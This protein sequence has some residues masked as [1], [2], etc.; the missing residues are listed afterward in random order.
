MGNIIHDSLIFFPFD[1]DF[2]SDTKIKSLKAHYGADGVTFYVY[3]LCA[4][5]RDKGYYTVADVYFL[6]NAADDL[7]MSPTKIGL[8]LNFLLER[9][10]FNDKLFQSDKVLTSRGI[11]RRFQ[12]AIETR[13]RKTPRTVR[14]EIWL[15]EKDETESFIKCARF[16]NCSEKKADFSEK[17]TVILPEICDKGKE[18]K[19][20]ESKEKYIKRNVNVSVG[21]IERICDYFHERTEVQADSALTKLL[22]QCLESGMTEK[23][24]LSTVDYVVS[25]NPKKPLPYF[26]A[27]LRKGGAEIKAQAT[28]P[29]EPTGEL[30]D[31]EKM[32]L[33]ESKQR[34][35][36]RTQREE[37]ET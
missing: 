8:L 7:G 28:V 30:K 11:Q 20:K 27:M 37:H 32:W 22:Q 25:K 29:T 12:N 24:A 9:S 17:N 15:L 10:L 35:E 14:S 13:A 16:G 6:E 4:I 2:F 34:R 26:V 31:W 21:V 3:L 5:Y 1:T 33:E 23:R 18:T 19:E 36:C